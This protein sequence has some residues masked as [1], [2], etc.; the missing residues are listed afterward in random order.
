[1]STMELTLHN[2]DGK[3]GKVNRIGVDK[4]KKQNQRQNKKNKDQADDDDSKEES[5][6]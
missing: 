3:A 1:M 2:S 4:K 6:E 5:G